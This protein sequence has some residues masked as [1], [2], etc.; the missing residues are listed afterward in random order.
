M[1]DEYTVNT[2]VEKIECPWCGKDNDWSDVQTD[3]CL[4]DG[5]EDECVECGKPIRIDS[6]DWNPVVCVSR[7]EAATVPRT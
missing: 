6:V 7:V 4:S 5:Y 2:E 1:S 3:G